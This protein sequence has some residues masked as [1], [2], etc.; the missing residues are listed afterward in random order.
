MAG[1]HHKHIEAFEFF[2]SQNNPHLQ[3]TPEETDGLWQLLL[4]L[5]KKK[6][7][8]AVHS[9][10]KEIIYQAF[11]LF[12]LE[13][14]ALLKNNIDHSNLKLT[15]KEDLVMRFM[16]LLKEHF[17]EERSVRYYADQ[18][19]ISPKHLTKTVK[20]VTGKTGGELID[21]MVVIEAKL[22]LDYLG[23][24]IANVAESLHFSDQFS[25]SK[26]FKKQTGITPTAYRSRL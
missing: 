4:L 20:E 22:L 21:E 25:F 1:W 16:K 24:S 15:R 8:Q 12:M 9:F 10:R 11:G 23:H 13:T 19:Y 17:R 2:S 14:V 7:L 6:E 5:Q 18:L 26:Y 3:L